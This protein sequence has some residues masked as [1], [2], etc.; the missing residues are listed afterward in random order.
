MTQAHDHVGAPGSPPSAPGGD[1]RTAG[2][3]S[4]GFGGTAVSLTAPSGKV[5]L[6]GAAPATDLAVGG[7]RPV[8]RPALTETEVVRSPGL[9]ADAG[10]GTAF[11]MKYEIPMDQVP[12]IKAWAAKHL[13]PDPHGNEGSYSTSS[14]YLDTPGWDIFHK[15]AGF[16]GSKLRVRRYGDAPFVF[17]ERKTKRGDRVRKRRSKIAPHDLAHLDAAEPPAGWDA[18]WFHRCMTRRNF[19]PKC[20]VG[21]RRTA[22]FGTAEGMPVRMTLDHDIVG[23]PVSRW[24]VSPLTG[25]QPL[26]PGGALV[27]LKFHLKIPDLFSQLLPSLPM[28]TARVSKYRRCVTVCGLRSAAD[29]VEPTTAGTGEAPS[30]GGAVLVHA[31]RNGSHVQNGHASN[32]LII[33]PSAGTLTNPAAAASTDGARLRF[34]ASAPVQG[35]ASPA[36][37]RLVGM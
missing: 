30:G 20:R 25:G 7:A 35:S 2:G 15:M 17:L 4:P 18:E 22:W 37:S 14:I 16:R 6:T 8:D 12:F 28:K 21:Y 34:A 23:V 32:G 36:R 10:L 26:L 13:R 3:A 19:E 33:P 9:G 29:K 31:D 27:E 24:D 11:E 1:R 5:L